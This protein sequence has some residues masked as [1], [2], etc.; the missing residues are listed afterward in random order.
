MEQVSG[1]EVLRSF[2]KENY[3]SD[4]DFA[5]AID[6][7]QSSVSEVLN[8]VRKKIPAEWCRPIEAATNGQITRHQLRPD[9]FD[10]PEATQ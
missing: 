6:K 9:L 5:R 4:S 3:E 7:P 2:V 8:G 1:I 10:D